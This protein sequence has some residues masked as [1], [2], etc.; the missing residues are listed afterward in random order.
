MYLCEHLGLQVFGQ[1]IL[2]IKQ[3][4]TP[5]P[6]FERQGRGVRPENRV[7]TTSFYMVY[8][9]I[10]II[11]IIIIVIMHVVNAGIIII[12]IMITLESEPRCQ[13]RVY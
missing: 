9:F 6:S 13:S 12:I 2:E 11:N 7:K 3:I 1:N 10:V 5:P 8:L 4:C